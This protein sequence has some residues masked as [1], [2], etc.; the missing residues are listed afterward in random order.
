MGFIRKIFSPDIPTIQQP[1]VT[2]KDLVSETSSQEPD[3]PQMGADSAGKK[4]GIN[5]LLVQSESIYK[6]G[7]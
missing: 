1:S 3:S 6:G 4:K 5:S 2:G 7:V